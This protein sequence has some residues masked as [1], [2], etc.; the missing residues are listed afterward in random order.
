MSGG[1]LLSAPELILHMKNKGIQ[2]NIMD[3]SVAMNYLKE[4]NNYFKLSAYRKNYSKHIDKDEYIDLEFAYL[5]DLAII[6]TRLRVL[7]IEMSLNIEHFA[8]V[9][10]LKNMEEIPAEDG[11]TIIDDY[12]KSLNEDQYAKLNAELSRNSTSIY[13]C[14]LY[15][16][17]KAH[18]P[19]WGFIELLSFGQFLWFYKFCASRFKDKTMGNNLYLMLTVKKIRNAAAHNNCI[20]N[21][22][23]AKARPHSSSKINSPP[24]NFNM[25]K[26]LSVLGIKFSTRKSKLDK[27]RILQ[28]L[29]CLY[30]HKIIVTS[31]GTHK[32]ICYNLNEFK[33]R[34]YR[35][36]D[37]KSNQTV[38]TFFDL[39][40]KI[41]D[42]W[43][44][45]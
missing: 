27:E 34:L 16:K 40:T 22:L 18:M 20:I 25:A 31:P 17:H 39:I 6:D 11:Y 30:A 3:E 42:N 43:F 38:S 9:A 32:H 21:N 19:I 24:P 33:S 14:D 2:F 5:V 12:T 10:L 28:I 29:T 15:Q 44:S 36:Y 8:K 13:C 23:R 7:L 4:N 41:I 26:E 1:K 37:Y 45:I 35:E